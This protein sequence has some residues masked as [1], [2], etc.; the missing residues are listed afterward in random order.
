MTI[1]SFSPT[2]NR[3]YVRR[4]DHEEAR[5]LRSEGA[6]IRELADRYGVTQ[7]AI[8]RATTPGA[9]ERDLEAGRR[10]R[11]S[12]CEECGGYAMKITGGKAQHNVD[13]RI[14]CVT[15]RGRNRR[16]RYRFDADGALI[17]VRCTSLDCANGE[18]WQ[19]PQNFPKGRPAQDLRDGGIHNCCRSC[20]TRMRQA[21]RERRKI[22]CV[23]CGKPRLPAGEKGPRQQDT[24]LCLACYRKS[25]TCRDN[26]DRG[27]RAR[28]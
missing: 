15:C 9:M 22:P 7:A 14:L 8:H 1:A 16:E 28:G 19:P 2:K 27:R 10:H 18:R 4:F 26:L 11:A 17:A 5:R 21:F 20:Q 6:T 25:A 13:G 12:T 23:Q 3:F 24:G